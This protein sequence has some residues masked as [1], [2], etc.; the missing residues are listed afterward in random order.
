LLET[1]KK[2]PQRT[3]GKDL[4]WESGRKRESKHVHL[5][6]NTKGKNRFKG[7]KRKN[8]TRAFKATLWREQVQEP[9]RTAGLR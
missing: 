3:S 7:G 8:R 6:G 5:G 4:H 9:D 2:G 1:K